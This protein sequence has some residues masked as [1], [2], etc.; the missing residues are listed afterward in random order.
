[1]PQSPKRISI[2]N[3]PIDIPQDMRDFF[4]AIKQNLEIDNGVVGGVEDKKPTI[5]E[6]IDAG[7]TNADKIT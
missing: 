2:P 1:M 6:M 3:I 4:V 5:Q 7:I